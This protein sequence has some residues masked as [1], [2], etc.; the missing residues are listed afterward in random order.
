MA[1]FEN[2]ES[3]DSTRRIPGSEPEVW[4]KFSTEF[5]DP[6]IDLETAF[7]KLFSGENL[8][9]KYDYLR[10]ALH[11]IDQKVCSSRELHAMK[12]TRAELNRSQL[13]FSLLV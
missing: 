10:S 11:F 1:F 4:L 13:T 12:S 6:G 7:K 2:L 3:R 9:M 8:I 5:F